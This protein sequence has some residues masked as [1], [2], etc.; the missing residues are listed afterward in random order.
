MNSK[1]FCY[2]CTKF[3]PNKWDLF[4]TG[5]CGDKAAKLGGF[6]DDENAGYVYTT[7]PLNTCGNAC[8]KCEEEQKEVTEVDPEI[9]E[10][11]QKH[12]EYFIDYL[13]ARI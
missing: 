11:I 8:R 10:F 9:E 4:R 3:H 6:I 13:K 2:Q 1:T 7:E 12:K 5:S